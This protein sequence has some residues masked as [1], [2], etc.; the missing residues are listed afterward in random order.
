[1]RKVLVGVVAVL[2]SLA[3]VPA[4]QAAALT[5]TA[6][7]MSVPESGN[8][9][10]T[11]SRPMGV[12]LDEATAVVRF[13]GGTGDA[14]SCPGDVTA[15]DCKV[16]V[17]LG[18]LATSAKATAAVVGDM[19]DEADEPLT[20]TIESVS[21]GNTVGMPATATTTIT[22]DDPTPSLALAAASVAEGTGSTPTRLALPVTLS[23]PSGRAVSVGYDLTAGTATAEDV[24]LASGTV[25]IPAGQT[26]GTLVAQVVGDALDEG[27][28]ETFTATL[29][30]PVNATIA[31]GKGSAVATIT[32][33][34]VA[35]LSVADATA[36]EGAAGSTTP[37]TFT[38]SLST[39]ATR[40][41]T[42]DYATADG[43]AVA[44]GDYAA[45][46]GRI[47]FAAGETTKE[48]RVAVAGDAV[49]EPDERFEV[50]LAAPVGA[51]VGRGTATGTITNDDDAAAQPAPQAPAG[52]GTGGGT[53]APPAGGA[54]P[55]TTTTAASQTPKDT[56]APKGRLARFT[57]RDRRTLTSS[58][59]CP[60][61]EVG[62]Q[63]V[64][65][66]FTVAAPRSKVKQLRRELKVAART[67]IVLGGRKATLK[68]PVKAATLRILRRAK[69]VEV[70]GYAVVRDAAL[71]VGTAQA[72]GVLKP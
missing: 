48:V 9:S 51:P 43:T 65:T 30:A 63:V 66:V 3:A 23:A 33:D 47:A 69:R 37:L 27:G 46:S 50:R 18:M 13:G 16:T 60:A 5:I 54:P 14:A 64:V 26:T 4:A 6:D 62:C 36:A 25:T 28:P 34:D 24:A 57:L 20:A 40:A 2:G 32:D 31:A 8:V 22:D 21:Q 1:M 71:N 53:A 44:P 68:L 11:V 56:V 38:V 70:R 49:A 35:Q 15:T 29:K 19:L 61:T 58:F 7:A 17:T 39:R 67:F 42:V 72:G 59:S 12:N 55:A 52:T 45:S 10:F 41:I